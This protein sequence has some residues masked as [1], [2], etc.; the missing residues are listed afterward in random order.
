M[1][2]AFHEYSSMDVKKHSHQKWINYWGSHQNIKAVLGVWVKRFGRVLGPFA[3][4][5]APTAEMKDECLQV[6]KDR[7][8]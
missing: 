4:G 6:K 5:C 8:K 2:F 1:G 7:S 3:A